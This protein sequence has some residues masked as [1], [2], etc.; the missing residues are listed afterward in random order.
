MGKALDLREIIQAMDFDE[1]ARQV[2]ANHARLESCERHDF[3]EFAFGQERYTCSRC[4]GWVT[5]EAFRWYTLG[6]EHGGAP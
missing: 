3:G 5:F 6:L 1:I 2:E 4:G